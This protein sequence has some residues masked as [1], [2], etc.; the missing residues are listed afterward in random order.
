M[1]L[2]NKEVDAS[3]ISYP[4]DIPMNDGRLMVVNIR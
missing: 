4:L 2:R 1:G 3:D